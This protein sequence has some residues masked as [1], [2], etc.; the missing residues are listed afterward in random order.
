M[1]VEVH[2]PVISGAGMPVRYTSPIMPTGRL[3]A[4]VNNISEEK[5][6]N[7][8]FMDS[9]WQFDFSGVDAPREWGLGF[10]MNF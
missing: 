2:P 9:I 3:T 8:G 6:L 5:F 10:E 4:F 1:V 7:S